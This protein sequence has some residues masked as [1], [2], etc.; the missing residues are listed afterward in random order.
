MNLVLVLAF[1]ILVLLGTGTVSANN[2]RVFYFEGYMDRPSTID[3]FWKVV[4]VNT[5]LFAEQNLTLIPIIYFGNK[6]TYKSLDEYVAESERLLRPYGDTSNDYVIGHSMGGLIVRK[7]VE[8]KNHEFK[9]KMLVEC[10]NGGT[11][12]WIDS[13]N[14]L[15]TTYE[16]VNDM[17]RGSAFMNSIPESGA[18]NQNYIEVRGSASLDF[19]AQVVALLGYGF[20]KIPGALQ[21]ILPDIDHV[22][23]VIDKRSVG[24]GIGLLKAH[25]NST[26][27]LFPKLAMFCAFRRKRIKH[28]LRN[29]FKRV[30]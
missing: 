20:T 14:K 17:H 26:F 10:P 4:R 16:S 15:N 30:F 8:V 29:L 21:V 2:P 12:W 6:T 13:F 11:S 19:K 24:I 3:L 18:I 27:P 23:L 28:Y 1:V 22:N 25:D 5:E 7:L 9:K